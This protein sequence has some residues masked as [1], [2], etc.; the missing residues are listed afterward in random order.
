MQPWFFMISNYLLEWYIDGDSDNDLLPSAS[1]P[2]LISQNECNHFKKEDSSVTSDI[3]NAK[4]FLPKSVG[5][6][7]WFAAWNNLTASNS[8]YA[9]VMNYFRWSELSNDPICVGL[10]IGIPLGCTCTMV[11]ASWSDTGL[12]GVLCMADAMIASS[13]VVLLVCSNL[14]DLGLIFFGQTRCNI[15]MTWFWRELKDAKFFLGRNHFKHCLSGFVTW[16][17][18]PDLEILNVGVPELPYMKESW[19]SRGI[20]LDLSALV[21][22]A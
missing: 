6:W 4:V 22:Y 20:W 1:Y 8:Y 17:S 12:S 13:L 14:L 19:R 2:T 15:Q 10:V 3:A 11:S 16:S 21:S 7:C 9:E 18:V 5:C